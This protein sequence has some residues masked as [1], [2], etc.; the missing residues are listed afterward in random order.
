MKIVSTEQMREI[1]H[2][3]EEMGISPYQLMEQ[4]GLAF[5]QTLQTFLGGNIAGKTVVAFIGPGNNGADGLIAS[6][7]LNI[8]GARLIVYLCSERSN[9]EQ[10]FTLL[11]DASIE[12]VQIN[13]P[14]YFDR[15]N[16]D[17]PNADIV[18]DAILGIGRTRQLSGTVKK[19][20]LRINQER[21][22]RKNLTVAS[23]DL[24]TGLNANTGEI[25]ESSV[26]P[27]ITISLG[28]PKVGFFKFPGATRI[29]QLLV[30]DIG[31]PTNVPV[32]HLPTLLTTDWAAKNLPLRS[33]DSN[34]G[35]FGKVMVLAGSENYIGAAFLACM[36]AARV[37]AG[38]IMLATTG[39]VLRIVATLMPDTT[40][41]P[42][43]EDQLGGYESSA[44][45][46]VLHTLSDRDALLVGCGL[47]THQTTRK[48]VRGVSLGAPRPTPSM[49]LDA[50]ALN[51]L[52]ETDNWWEQLRFGCIMTPHPK[53]MARLLKTTVREVQE[54][55]I[56][57]ARH[58]ALQWGVTVILKGAFTVIASP[59]G[60]IRINPFANPILATSGTG[61]VLAGMI[62]GFIA[63]NVP[64]Y[65]AACLGTFIHGATGEALTARY[66]DRGALASELLP[67]IP[68]T[69][70]DIIGRTFMPVISQYL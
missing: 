53:E 67:L 15:L 50:D 7:H 33:R 2:Y 10:N 40:Y 59:E 18:I 39:N 16:I 8:W 70:K 68:T 55:R 21:L 69:I 62:T 19:I 27:D 65:D 48:L 22:S 56:A 61:D 63:Q 23:L 49:V 30:A 42:L 57:C 9:V 66:G 37:G 17:L 20:T 44:A 64:P 24:P 41:L 5:A 54:D 34:K 32:N 28:Y 12:I 14:T 43:L 52:A 3:S 47:G 45:E 13:D 36:G 46:K 1:E 35:S 58:A 60:N 6:R 25:D 26:D 51:T 31:L 29:G 4:A 38:N 11:D